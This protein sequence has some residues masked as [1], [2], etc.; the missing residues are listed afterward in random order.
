ME[1]IKG[2]AIYNLKKKGKFLI[3]NV[4]R[5]QMGAGIAAEPFIWLDGNTPLNEVAKQIM[6][7]LSKTKTGLPNPTDWKE[8]AKKVFEKHRVKKTKRLI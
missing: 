3:H 7:A 1:E 2:A 5:L 8:S 4:S 6:Y